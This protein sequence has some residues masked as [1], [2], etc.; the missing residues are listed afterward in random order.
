MADRKLVAMHHVSILFKQL[1]YL[2]YWNKLAIVKPKLGLQ[3]I[4]TTFPHKHGS[5]ALSADVF[6]KIYQKL[7]SL[8]V[9]EMNFTG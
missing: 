5:L 4:L 7:T 2:A 8:N 6:K 9:Y 1:F 3:Y